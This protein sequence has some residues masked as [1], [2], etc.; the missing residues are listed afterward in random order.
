[1][2]DFCRRCH[3]YFHTDDHTSCIDFEGLF[4][5]I[6]FEFIGIHQIFPPPEFYA[7]QYLQCCIVRKFGK[8]KFANFANCQC[9]TKLKQSKLV[10]IIA[11]CLSMETNNLEGAKGTYC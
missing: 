8:G 11:E 5:R 6:T 2:V 9:I 1:M 10:L 4:G 7:I 3:N